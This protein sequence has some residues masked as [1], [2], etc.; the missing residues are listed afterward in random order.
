MDL[1]SRPE[2][3]T[4]VLVRGG[5]RIRVRKKDV[6]ETEVIYSR[7]PLGAKEGKKVDSSLEPPDVRQRF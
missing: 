1:P 6:T 4:K 2:I 7:Q 5:R 3:I